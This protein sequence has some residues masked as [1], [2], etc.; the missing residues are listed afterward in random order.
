MFDESN[1]L[2]IADRIEFGFG[3]VCALILSIAQSVYGGKN[4]PKKEVNMMQFVPDWE[5]KYKKAEPKG[6]S[7]EE[8]KA[9][10]LSVLSKASKRNKKRGRK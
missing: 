2:N 3:R 9:I 10:M 5:A 8:M 4:Q 6:Q 1:P 7:V